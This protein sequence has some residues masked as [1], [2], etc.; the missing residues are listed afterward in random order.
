[1]G[2]FETFVALRL[3]RGVKRQ[4]GFLSLTTFISTAGIA[5][6][7]MALIIVI[8]VMTGFD[9]D[10]KSKIL[11]VNAHVLVM[12]AGWRLQFRPEGRGRDP[13][14]PGVI[15]ANPFIYTQVMYSAPGNI[16]GGVMRGLDLETI[17]RGG[18]QALEVL[19]GTVR[20]PGGRG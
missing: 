9:Q 20:R 4:K 15:S 12:K 18:P 8:G 11:S 2:F 14:V 16:S 19:Q 6:G 13:E 3:L 10:L 17:R 1:M 7:V 5:V